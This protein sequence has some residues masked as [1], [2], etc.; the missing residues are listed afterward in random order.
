MPRPAPSSHHPG[1]VCSD[2]EKVVLHL[3]AS[4]GETTDTNTELESVITGRPPKL[5]QIRRFTR[6][7]IHMVVCPKGGGFRLGYRA[8]G[9]GRKVLALI[10]PDAVKTTLV[11]LPQRVRAVYDGMTGHFAAANSLRNTAVEQMKAAAREAMNSGDPVQGAAIVAAAM[12][13]ERFGEVTLTTAKA[14]AAAGITL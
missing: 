3:I 9:R 11:P 1:R 5:R 12:D 2:V 7:R 10:D 4:G 14:L 6:A 8:P 13:I